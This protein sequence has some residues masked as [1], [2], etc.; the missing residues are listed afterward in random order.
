MT[1]P[2]FYGVLGFLI[3]SLD[4]MLS[5]FHR[6]AQANWE[7]SLRLSGRLSLWWIIT[8]VSFL[9]GYALIG[10][11]SW[12]LVR[13][14]SGGRL[15]PLSVSVVIDLAMTVLLWSLGTIF[16]DPLF[17]DVLAGSGLLYLP[18][19]LLIAGAAWLLVGAVRV[20]LLSPYLTD[21]PTRGT[22]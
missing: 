9:V 4:W 3:V 19:V 5:R 18:S 15:T 8:G 17:S 1:R 7:D 2:V 22:A 13:K 21:Q 6:W 16:Q 11:I 12:I 20:R 10:A 14:Y